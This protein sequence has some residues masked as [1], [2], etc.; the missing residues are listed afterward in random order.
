MSEDFIEKITKQCSIEAI[1]KKPK[2]RTRK[3]EEEK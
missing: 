1:I 3:D 2:E